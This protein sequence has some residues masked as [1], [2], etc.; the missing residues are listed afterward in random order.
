MIR[1]SVPRERAHTLTVLIA[2]AITFLVLLGMLVSV[3]RA[4]ARE[5][6][7]EAAARV[8]V[9]LTR[10]LTLSGGDS[11]LVYTGA[12]ATMADARLGASRYANRG[13]AGYLYES[14]GAFLAVGSAYADASDAR[15]AAA[16]LR[17][18]GR[19]AFCREYRDRSNGQRRESA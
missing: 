10:S 15:A 4:K 11:H 8:S 12:Y 9:R 3:C 2:F 16:R 18:R 17:G 6:E 19:E 7:L 14:D 1:T 5:A 13:A